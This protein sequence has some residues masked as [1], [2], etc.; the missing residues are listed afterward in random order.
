M[1]LLFFGTLTKAHRPQVPENV[2]RRNYCNMLTAII[3]HLSLW[4]NSGGAAPLRP[5][6][7]GTKTI[8]R[9]AVKNV[10]LS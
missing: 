3:S 7:V 2:Q 10:N 8:T 9:L 4:L 1:S 5:K 6:S